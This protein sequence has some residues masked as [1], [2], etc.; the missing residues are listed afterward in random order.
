MNTLRFAAAVACT[1]ITAGAFAAE[2][3]KVNPAQINPAKSADIAHHNLKATDFPRWH[4]LVPNVYAYEDTLIT[5]EF[6]FTTNS[7]II[8]TTEGVVLVDGQDNE[9]RA[10]GLI[11]A[12]KKITPQPLKYVVIASD[13]GDHVGGFPT[14]KAAFP[15]AVYISSTASLKT[16][17]G[18]KRPVLATEIVDD[19]RSL[20][21]GGTEIQILNLGRGHTGGD[22]VVYLPA[23]KIMFM[24]ELYDRN[25]FPP[26]IT[27]HPSEWVATVKK[28]QAMDVSWF[29]PGHGFTT[30]TQAELKADLAEFLKAV[31]LVVSEGKRLHAAGVP[32]PTEKD[33]PAN[34]QANWGPYANST[35]AAGQAPRAL[36]RMYAEIDGKLPK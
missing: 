8:V 26:M 2:P 27:G 24:S 33:C 32:C 6:T 18:A 13:H 30:G 3:A 21:L 5:P 16:M 4:Q 1:L 15:D 12:I 23:S 25:I 36:A 35:A 19:K 7:L 9:A 31:E 28:A 34:K 29:I 11:G 10:N 14:L 20:K 22:L 17:Q